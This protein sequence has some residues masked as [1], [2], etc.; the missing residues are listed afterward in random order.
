ERGRK[1]LRDTDDALDAVK[2]QAEGR[3][4]PLRLGTS[5]GVVVDLLPQVLEAL[6][7]QDAGIDVEVAIL[8]SGE[9]LA[10]LAAGTL[11]IG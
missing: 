9:A 11:D 1:L 8:G 2:R 7:A 5:T 10:R 3:T 4:R 6:G